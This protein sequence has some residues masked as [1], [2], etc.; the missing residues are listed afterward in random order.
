M[1]LSEIIQSTDKILDRVK[2]FLFFLIVIFCSFCIFLKGI[3]TS[4][5]IPNFQYG[6]RVESLDIQNII[7]S[8]R[9]A[10]VFFHYIYK[11]LYIINI[12][13]Y[14][15]S[16]VLQ[17][18]GMIL[19]AI[20]ATIIFHIFEVYIDKSKKTLL[21]VY[22]LSIIMIFV[23]PFMIET[24]VYGAFDFA[25]GMLFSVLGGLY[26]DRKRYILSFL[27]GFLGLSTYQANIFIMFIIIVFLECA[28]HIYTDSRFNNLIIEE[29][30][31]IS[32]CIAIVIVNVVI[33]KLG[34]TVINLHNTVDAFIPVKNVDINII[35]LHRLKN[36][37]LMAKSIVQHCYGMLPEHSLLTM[38]IIMF[39]G[40]LYISKKNNRLST[41][42]LF[43]MASTVC[44][45]APFSFG[46]ITDIW[47]PQ[48]TSLGL[49]FAIGMM[50][51]FLIIVYSKWGYEQDKTNKVICVYILMVFIYIWCNTQICNADAY[52]SRAIDEYEAK[53]IE[54]EIELYEKRSGNEVTEIASCGG[55]G[56]GMESVYCYPYLL[57][58]YKYACPYHR[59]MYDQW[60]QGE[61]INYINGTDYAVRLMETEEIEKYFGSSTSGNFNSDEQLRFVGSTLFWRVY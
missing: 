34:V 7:S 32:L 20:S 10:G 25:M 11:T 23:N 15:N 31:G 57:K 44:I 51:I 45:F 4:D 30:K 17:I 28:R 26:W 19:F 5:Y 37:I 42:A 14:E 46:I 52:I 12:S 50:C 1:I 59:I 61:F 29:T 27:F 55:G 47:Y 8:A 48:R 40:I 49:F 22:C 60:A 38:W 33:Q 36:C 2:V 24:Y 9:Y 56:S 3:I 58:H 18:F 39:A 6:G 16:W 13:H 43:C 53:S 35:S 54:T 21:Y 41:M